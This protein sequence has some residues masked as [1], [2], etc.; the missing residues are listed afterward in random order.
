MVIA[1]CAL[2]IAGPLLIL[3]FCI[4]VGLWIFISA[5]P[6]IKR[7]AGSIALLFGAWLLLFGA[8]GF[9]GVGFLFF[10]DLMSAALNFYI[11]LFNDRVP[12]KWAI[13]EV[14]EASFRN[15]VWFCPPLSVLGLGVLF[16]KKDSPLSMGL[17]SLREGSFSFRKTPV[18]GIEVGVFI[19]QGFHNKKFIITEKALNHHVHICGAS[20][21][22]KSVLIQHIIKDR[23]EKGRGMIFIDLKGD[24]ETLMK[25]RGW[26]MDNGREKKLKVFS[27]SDSDDLAYYNPLSRGNADQITDRIIGAYEWSEEFYR[28]QASGNLRRIVRALVCLRDQ[29][30]G[31][32][33]F[34]KI[35]KALSSSDYLLE[36]KAALSPDQATLQDEIEEVNRVIRDKDLD[37]NLAKLKGHIDEICLT[38]YAERLDNHKNGID[39]L[40]AVENSEIIYFVLSSRDYPSSA[41]NLAKMLTEDIKALTAHIDATIPEAQR[42]GFQIIIDE[43]ADFAQDSF[44]SFLDRTR[45]SK[46]G[47]VIAHQ[48]LADLRAISETF[49]D[50]VLNI[51]ATSIIFQTKVQDS[52]EKFASF[53]G[54][55]TAIKE[56]ERSSR[57][58]AG[59]EFRTGEKSVR[60]TEEF[61]VHPNI[62]KRL[63]VGECYVTGSF[64]KKFA[65]VVKVRRPD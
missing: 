14:S 57:I 51:C 30:K 1:V 48:E 44:I 11:P 42:T 8:F 56:T 15:Y 49:P 16:W 23:I 63:Q 17:Q 9:K 27:L 40:R 46:I 29:G 59:V 55:R 34:G 39:L 32:V 3:S 43:F 50:R 60:E 65:G 13:K 6:T 26:S 2:F 47:C 20:G 22:G 10:S 41:T 45:S 35:K 61:L 54:T 24:I 33:T 52:A 18:D 38:N 58:V 36:I 53:S 12:D 25:V 19:D 28:T 64:P 4:A 21:F 37:R 62:I 31:A 7:I 5:Q